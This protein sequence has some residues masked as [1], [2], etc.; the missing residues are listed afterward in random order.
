MTYL[1]FASKFS[2]LST[3]A[4]LA[5]LAVPAVAAEKSVVVREQRFTSKGLVAVGRMPAD[6]RD[7]FGETFGSG[8]GMTLDPATWRKTVD[9]YEGSLY[10]LPDRGYNVEGTTDYRPRLNRLTIRLRPVQPG[11]SPPAEQ[12]QS[13]LEA[14]LTE[15]FLFSDAAGAPMTGLDPEGV[16]AGSQD[17]PALPASKDGKISLD[18]EAIVRMPDGSFFVSDEYGPA[19]YRFSSDGRLLAATRPPEAFSPVRKGDLNFSSNNPGPDAKAPV[20][21]HP[22]RG[23]QNNQGFEGMALTPDGQSLV[24]ILQS[25]TRQDGGDA[26]ATRRFTRA[27]VYDVSDIARLTLVREHVVPLPAF[28]GADGK[29]L[30]AAQS[31]LVALGDDMFLLLSRDSNNGHGMKGATSRYRGIDLLDLR[32]ATNIAGTDFDLARPVAPKG[33]LDAAVK[34]AALIPFIDMND[35][36][37]L[38]RFGLRNGAPNDRDNLSEKWEAMSLV[39]VMDEAAPDDYF[40]LVANDNDFLTQRGHQVGADYAA[41]TDVDTMFLV[42]RVT[43]PKSAMRAAVGR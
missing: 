28:T 39:S 42:Y 37:D 18:A 29:P 43:L 7:S 15:T 16:R 26:P 6:L 8:S 40:L 19:I 9:G 11:Q 32:G 25:A 22:E 24:V 20:P 2:A 30:V 21:A 1:S 38:S 31:E 34:P 14:T 10:L 41:A 4:L 17:L 27:L 33:V 13:G 5:H 12:R 36:A 35:D 3:L 23:R